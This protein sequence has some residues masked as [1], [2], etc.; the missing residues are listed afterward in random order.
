MVL[1]NGAVTP[2]IKNMRKKFMAK[3]ALSTLDFLHFV[4][5]YMM[6]PKEM[7]K[8]QTFLNMCATTRFENSPWQN[9]TKSNPELKKI[10]IMANAIPTAMLVS[11]SGTRR[12]I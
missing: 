1:N 10:P 11:N 7:M 4:N 5:S 9:P 2:N 3:V 12:V 6:N 8:K